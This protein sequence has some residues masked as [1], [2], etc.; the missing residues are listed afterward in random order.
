MDEAWEQKAKSKHTNTNTNT[1]TNSSTIERYSV[2]CTV[3]RSMY[4]L[5]STSMVPAQQPAP[6]PGTVNTNTFSAIGSGSNNNQHCRPSSVRMGGT[7]IVVN[8]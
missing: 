2:H 6:V 3:L 8:G 1:N 5:C 7:K 4:I